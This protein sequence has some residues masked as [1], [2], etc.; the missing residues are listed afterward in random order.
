MFNREIFGENRGSKE[1]GIHGEV[2][3][4]FVTYRGQSEN[5]RYIK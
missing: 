1:G 3:R 5:S 2:R 4:H